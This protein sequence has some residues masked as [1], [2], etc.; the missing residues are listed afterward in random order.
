MFISHVCMYICKYIFHF[1]ISFLHTL[2]LVCLVSFCGCVWYFF[3]IYYS[4]RCRCT[5]A[6]KHRAHF[7]GNCFRI[8]KLQWSQ[9]YQKKGKIYSKSPK[10]IWI[11]LYVHIG[12]GNVFTKFSCN[13]CVYTSAK[14][15]KYINLIKENN[16]HIVW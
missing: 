10:K 4:H 9:V 5:R 13:T 2:F 14:E 8:P 15:P 12:M 16:S 1:G 3:W 11:F 6:P 7:Y